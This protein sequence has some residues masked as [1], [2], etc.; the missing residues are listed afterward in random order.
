MK[1]FLDEFLNSRALVSKE[2][3]LIQANN[4]KIIEETQKQIEFI[5]VASSDRRFFY[6]ISLII[7]ALFLFAFA[8]NKLL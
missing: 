7:L 5:K 6:F 4:I 8:Y 2:N 1:L 3:E